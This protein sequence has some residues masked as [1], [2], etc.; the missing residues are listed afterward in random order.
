MK[1]QN[2]KR[3]RR[4][5]RA[6]VLGLVFSLLLAGFAYQPAEAAALKEEV[7]YVRLCNDGSVGDVYIV[8]SFELDKDR[9]SSTTATMTMCRI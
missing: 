1:N 5:R 3:P 7:V 9:R 6:A 2:R 4:V 8:N